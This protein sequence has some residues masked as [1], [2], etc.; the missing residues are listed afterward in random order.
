MLFLTPGAHGV[1]QG[2]PCPGRI[3]P[4][5]APPAPPAR[6]PGCRPP[7][8]ARPCCRRQ[9]LCG[10]RA[11]DHPGGVRGDDQG[12]VSAWASP[13]WRQ[14]G[15]G[16]LVAPPAR[17][18]SRPHPQTQSRRPATRAGRRDANA[19]TRRRQP[20]GRCPAGQQQPPPPTTETRAHPQLYTN[21]PRP[22]SDFVSHLCLPPPPLPSN[23]NSLPD[24]TTLRTTV[25]PPP[26]YLVHLSAR[27]LSTG[28][29]ARMKLCNTTAQ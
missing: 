14:Q 9:R 13:T 26:H 25:F 20:A 7:H 4:L 27:D 19:R 2:R 23:L 11:A 22:P 28:L 29:P 24:C 8:A 15:E 17:S 16:P 1:E 10:R 12:D 21:F 18:A 6:S 3:A 5:A